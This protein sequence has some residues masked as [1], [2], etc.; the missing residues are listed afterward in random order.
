MESLIRWPDK[1]HPD[2]APIY[3][4]NEIES[5]AQPQQ[6]WAWLIRARNWPKWYPNAKRVRTGT[7]QLEAN[8]IFRWTT[9]GMRLKS[10]VEEFV[11]NQRIAWSAHGLGIDVYHA[12]LIKKTA[13]GSRIITE[14]TQYGWACSLSK[15]V[16][17]NRMY[18]QHQIWLANLSKKAEQGA[19]KK[20]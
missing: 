5:N 12:W 11:P 2:R 20:I 1:F 3:I 15:R 10:V 6:V 17:P 8:A 7:D 14:E 18:N 13:S 9:F 16:F 19:P 4:K